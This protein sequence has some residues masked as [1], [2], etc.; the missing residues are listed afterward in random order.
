MDV[1]LDPQFSTN[2]SFSLIHLSPFFLSFSS[3][4]TGFIYA[5]YSRN[6]VNAPSTAGSRYRISRFKHTEA[7]AKSTASLASEFVVWT[8]NSGYPPH[9]DEFAYPVSNALL[10]RVL[11]SGRF[12]VHFRHRYLTFVAP[13]WGST[14]L[15]TGSR[16]T[17]CHAWRPWY[18]DLLILLALTL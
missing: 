5:I 14:F 3:E 10:S 6:S 11:S 15:W 1:V 7:G 2:G 12:L 8:D 18:F 16:D 13:L 17:L 4:K 9:E